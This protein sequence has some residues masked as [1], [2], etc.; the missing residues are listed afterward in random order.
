MKE[1][2]QKGINV[3]LYIDE[4]PVAGQLGAI[5]NRAMS[6]IDITNKINGSWSNSLSG[7][8]QWNVSCNGI[9]IKD[10]DSFGALENAFMT[11]QKIQVSIQ[12]ADDRAYTGTALITDFP[13]QAVYNDNYKYS[14]KLLG[15]GPLDY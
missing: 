13:L 4:K 6:S 12:V 5:L 7:V 2:T 14:L 1:Q 8:R 9:Y 11:N 10:S 3:V 15:V